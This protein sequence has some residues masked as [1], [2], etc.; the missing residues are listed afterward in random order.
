MLSERQRPRSSVR[1]SA[2][3]NA[4]KKTGEAAVSGSPPDL[5]VTDMQNRF[6]QLFCSTGLGLSFTHCIRCQ[7]NKWAS[8]Y[9]RHQKKI[10]IQV[11]PWVPS[12]PNQSHLQHILLST[13]F[14]LYET[15]Y[16]SM[17]HTKLGHAFF[18]ITPF[19]IHTWLTSLYVN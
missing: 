14:P 2:H 10:Q 12:L 17:R 13:A 11:S 5:P 15:V 18:G 3:F 4:Q 9:C 6:L 8:V 7:K 16:L 1:S 19:H